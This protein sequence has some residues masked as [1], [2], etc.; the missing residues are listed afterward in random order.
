MKSHHGKNLPILS[1]VLNWNGAKYLKLTLDTL[2]QQTAT[3]HHILVID[4]A[5]TDQSYEIAYN[6]SNVTLLRL[7][8]NV[9]FARG[10]NAILDQ[11]VNIP[12]D[13]KAGWIFFS[14]NDVEYS[15][16]ILEELREIAEKNSQI[17]TLTPWIAFGGK[18]DHLWYGGAQMIPFIGYVGHRYLGR[19]YHNLENYKTEITD[20]G[21]GCS[22][23]LLARY[24]VELGGFDIGY[25]H[26]CE[27]LDLC[28]RLKN[29]YKGHSFVY[30][31]VLAYH[32][33]STS[34]KGNPI[35]YYWRTAALTRFFWKH[36]EIYLPFSLIGVLLYSMASGFYRSGL[37]GM[38][39]ALKGW[40]LGMK[41]KG[42]PL[43]W[44]M[45]KSK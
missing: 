30:R 34:L 21:T 18:K 6:Y 25:P 24:F 19:N 12:F 36:K 7:K 39:N 42:K 17:L 5:S 1:V 27:D 26:Y 8:E 15:P 9:G 28:L 35:K 45:I 32:Y 3:P 14:N 23:F 38:V 22:L 13:W 40:L 41:I 31:K 29:Q 37:K 16:T 11:E 2:S 43:K 4:N 10:N 33:V 20:Y 44:E